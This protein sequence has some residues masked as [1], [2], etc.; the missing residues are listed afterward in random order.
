MCVIAQWVAFKSRPKA[1]VFGRL[2]LADLGEPVP[3]QLTEPAYLELDDGWLVI[4]ECFPGME[5]MEWLSEGGWAL[6]G[7]VD[8][9]SRF[10]LAQGYQRGQACWSVI[11]EAGALPSD[12]E[13]LGSLPKSFAGIVDRL[14]DEAAKARR[15]GE[16]VDAPFRIPM[17]LAW[18]ECG[19]WPDA[20]RMGAPTMIKLKV[21]P[22]R[23]TLLRRRMLAVS[24]ANLFR[25]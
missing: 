6:A 24:A 3:F 21:L 1:E 23:A 18:G 16:P 2:G 5:T 22:K 17:D 19:F 10:S 14:M 15:A 20:E 7:I 11:Y 8:Q 13:A 4:V 12:L 25:R 9:A